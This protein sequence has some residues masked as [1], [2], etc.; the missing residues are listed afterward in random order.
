MKSIH[1]GKVWLCMDLKVQAKT[2]ELLR[3]LMRVKERTSS[4]VEFEP[5]KEA[6]LKMGNIRQA[7][8]RMKPEQQGISSEYLYQFLQELESDVQIN[9]HTIM[10]V[11]NGVVI[12]EGA[13]SPFRLDCWHVGHSLCKSITA[14]AIGMLIEEEK[15]TLQDRIVK[16]F[17]KRVNPIQYLKQ[18]GITVYQ[19]LTMTSG[20]VFAE[21]GAVTENDWVKCFLESNVKQDATLQFAYN[22]MNTYMLSAIVKELTQEG[23]TEYLKPR[24]WEPL[25]IDHVYWEKC[26]KGIEKGGWGLYLCSEDMAK[27]GQL[28][29]QKGQWKGTQLV[30]EEWIDQMCSKKVDT[31]TEMSEYGYG[32]QVWMSGRKDSFICNGML[33]Q[34]IIVYPDLS[35]VIVTTSGSNELFPNSRL[36]KLIQKY[37]EGEFYPKVSKESF[38]SYERL[39]WKQ[40]KLMA[41]QNEFFSKKVSK[42]LR[43]DGMMKKRGGWGN[44]KKQFL[45]SVVKMVEYDNEILNLKD[46]VYEMEDSGIGVLPLFLQVF[47]NNYSKG[48][49]KI[50]FFQEGEVFGMELLEED[51]IYHIPIGFTSPLYNDISINQEVYTIGTVGEFTRDEDENLVL[52]I[53]IFFVE[54]TSSRRVKLFF[55]NDMIITKWDEKPG[56]ELIVKGLDSLRDGNSKASIMNLLVGKAGNEVLMNKLKQVI[57]PK[58]VGKLLLTQINNEERKECGLDDTT[59]L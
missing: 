51:E 43:K 10:I 27:I 29:L 1:I 7:F 2:A 38:F 15:L 57:E 44:Q 11:R 18:K 8:P 30:K 45:Y 19:L 37:F 56:R 53:E 26:P 13:F 31:P 58:L 35:M 6:F 16:I 55:Q 48:I 22:S 28:F 52:K 17:E 4:L 47:H 41:I 46:R 14:L 25:G 24:L 3:Q 39:L 49:K 34:N 20:V 40:K 42:D 36:L 54:T 23:L 9:P 5:Q 21:P 33:G 12:L 50:T 59:G 32:Y